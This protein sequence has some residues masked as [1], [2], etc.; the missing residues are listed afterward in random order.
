[1][2]RP[3]KRPPVERIPPEVHPKTLTDSAFAEWVEGDREDEASM[4]Q[5]MAYGACDDEGT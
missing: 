5:P 1:M 4:F 3:I 2:T